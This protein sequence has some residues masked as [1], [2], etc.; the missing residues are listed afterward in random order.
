MTLFSGQ[1]GGPNKCMND[2][3]RD[4]RSTIQY[5]SSSKHDIP[6]RQLDFCNHD[7]IIETKSY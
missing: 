5:L 6:Q 7:K 2:N 4:T 3:R 1:G